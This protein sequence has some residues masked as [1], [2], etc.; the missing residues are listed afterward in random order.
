[1]SQVILHPPSSASPSGGVSERLL[2]TLC[3]HDDSV[4]CLALHPEVDVVVSGSSDGS[5]MVH[6]LRHGRYLRSIYRSPPTTSIPAMRAEDEALGGGSVGRSPPPS[7]IDWVGVSGQGY[8]LSYSRRDRTLHSYSVNGR[9]LASRTLPDGVLLALCFSEDEHVLLTGGTDRRVSMLWCHDL[10]L[11]DSG[12]RDGL[13]GLA[14]TDGACNVRIICVVYSWM[15]SLS[16]VCG[17]HLSRCLLLNLRVLLVLQVNSTPP[18]PAAIR[19]L[20]LSQRER[21]LLVGLENGQLYILAPDAEYLRL[22]LRKR[23]EN[24]GFC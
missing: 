11:A 7:P 10:R 2:H 5:L 23:L 3:G 20:A 4:L 14:T 17:Y 9:P 18:F 1:M 24:L 12:P 16:Y 13:R 21:H 8:I 6:S 15:H 19:S 22:R